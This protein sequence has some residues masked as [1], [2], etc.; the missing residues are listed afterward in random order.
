MDSVPCGALDQNWEGCG[1][2]RTSH[3]WNDEGIGPRKASVMGSFV[4]QIH[5]GTDLAQMRSRGWVRHFDIIITIIDT[6]NLYLLRILWIYA[7]SGFDVWKKLESLK[8][9]TDAG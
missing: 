9:K 5:H 2:S 6:L 7:I 1:Q 4:S 8:M 3:L